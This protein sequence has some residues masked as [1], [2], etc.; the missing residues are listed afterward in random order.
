MSAITTALQELKDLQAQELSN[1][2][3]ILDKQDTEIKANGV[4]TS[5]TAAAL[6][7]ATRRLDQIAADFKGLSERLDAD[8][9]E[10]KRL[11]LAG[12]GDASKSV[13]QQFVESEAYKN[14]D[15]VSKK[16]SD[17]L[18][19]KSFFERKAPPT[20]TLTGATLGNQASYLYPTQRV[21][22]L[23]SPPEL[24]PRVRDLFTVIPTTSGAVDF[25]RET[26]FTNGAAATGE[27]EVTPQSALTFEEVARPMRTVSHWIP[28]TRQILQDAP[29]LQSYIDT[30]L[31]YGLALAEDT[32]LL[33][34]DGTGVHLYG[35][36]ADGDIQTL[37]QAAGDNKADAIRRAITKVALSG[38]EASGIVLHPNDWEDIELM[39][40][41]ES[42]YIWVNITIGGERRLWRLPVV[43]SQAI[44]EGDFACGAF[45]LAATVWDREEASVRVAEQHS[46][47]FTRNMVALLAEE[48]LTVTLYRPEAICLGEFTE[49]S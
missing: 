45:N 26:G 4:S 14:F 24:Q 12:G 21:P 43:V 18:Q 13:G 37:T 36:L 25:I 10:R 38:Y 32:E 33:Y 27:G 3:G 30:R 19:I 20:G 39:K 29:G 16:E 1:I 48:R 15:P 31:T 35:V 2:K 5:E 41:D 46:D 11:S 22:G 7:E 40:D 49:G 47:Y 6:G 28:V 42:R 34:G 23:I 17:R 44:T 9:A 8:E